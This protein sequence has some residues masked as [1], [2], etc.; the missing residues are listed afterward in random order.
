LDFDQET[1]L[2]P[3]LHVSETG[4]L[5]RVDQ[6]LIRALRTILKEKEMYD[7]SKLAWIDFFGVV[8][9]NLSPEAVVLVLDWPYTYKGTTRKE[10]KVRSAPV[11]APKRVEHG[12][13]DGD[14]VGGGPQEEFSGSSGG[15]RRSSRTHKTSSSRYK[16]YYMD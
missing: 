14:F 12:D 8:V 5:R 4:K 6:A 13:G 10:K 9:S 7:G 2:D 15:E 11:K 3:L 1:I 16:D